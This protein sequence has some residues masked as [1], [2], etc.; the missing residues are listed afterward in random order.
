MEIYSVTDKED[1]KRY[2]NESYDKH[3]A[4][5]KDKPFEI[6]FKLMNKTITIKQ[7][8][9][10]EWYTVSNGDNERGFWSFEDMVF[11]LERYCDDLD[12]GTAESNMSLVS[13]ISHGK[14]V[15]RA[16]NYDRS[17]RSESQRHDIH[18]DPD[19]ID[20][21]MPICRAVA[22]YVLVSPN[23][24]ISLSFTGYCNKNELM[25]TRRKISGQIT[26]MLDDADKI[27]TGYDINLEK[28][29]YTKSNIKGEKI[30]DINDVLG[31]DIMRDFYAALAECDPESA[32]AKYDEI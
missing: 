29:D 28:A 16:Y 26:M 4:D 13:Y 15:A 23:R 21:I 25:H 7:E 5:N 14:L 18:V 19:N 3:R 17:V 27:K 32:M 10:C 20:E 9:N 24:D 11:D 31:L 1:L 12:N 6:Q 8:D 22:D 30:T 2:L